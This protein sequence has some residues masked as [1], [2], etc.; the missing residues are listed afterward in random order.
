MQRVQHVLQWRSRALTNHPPQ[1]YDGSRAWGEREG[2]DMVESTERR[3]P[4][5]GVITN[6]WHPDVYPPVQLAASQWRRPTRGTRSS[7]K[8][9]FHTS[10]IVPGPD[11]KLW[12]GL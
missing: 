4:S 9:S 10:S 1:L 11:E 6:G 2:E 7:P 3:K 12:V 5:S 8:S